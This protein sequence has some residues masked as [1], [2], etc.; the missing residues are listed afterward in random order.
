MFVR[1]AAGSDGAALADIY[2]HYIDHTIVGAMAQEHRRREQ[3][4]R[5]Q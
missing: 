5:S 2:N 4:R 3:Q 1:D